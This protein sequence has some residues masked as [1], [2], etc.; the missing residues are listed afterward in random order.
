MRAQLLD[1]AN[2][3]SEV[4][5]LKARAHLIDKIMP[6]K[7]SSRVEIDESNDGE[8]DKL[9][10]N[11]DAIFGNTATMEKDVPQGDGAEERVDTEESSTTTA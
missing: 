5:R 7:V 2:S 9:L 1:I 6:T 4:N 8:V 10:S 3:K 11:F